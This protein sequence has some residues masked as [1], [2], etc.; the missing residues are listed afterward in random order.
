MANHSA[1]KKSIRQTIKRTAINTSRKSRIKTFITKLEKALQETQIDKKDIDAM[2]HT[3]ESEIMRGVNKGVWK[4]NTAS[5]K[6]GRLA[7]KVKK[8][9]T[10]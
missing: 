2:F 1:T 7:A 9:Q 3:T 5:R 10:N 6:V 4:K 8:Y